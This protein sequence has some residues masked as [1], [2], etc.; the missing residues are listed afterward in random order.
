[1]E[2]NINSNCSIHIIMIGFIFIVCFKI[3]KLNSILQNDSKNNVFQDGEK[4]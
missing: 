4:C 3:S 2:H 1:M